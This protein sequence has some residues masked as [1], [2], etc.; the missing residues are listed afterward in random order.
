MDKKLVLISA[1]GTGGHMF[2]ARAL[3]EELLKRGHD[4]A[5]ATD[6]RGYKFFDGMDQV[7]RIV[8]SSAAYK[9]GIMGKASAVLSLLKG[10]FQS[11]TLLSRLKPSVVVGFG[12]YPSAPPVFAAQ[13][14]G[15]PTVLHEQNAILGLANQMLAPKAHKIA[16]STENTEGI[17]KNRQH[18]CIVTG[19]PVREEV[20]ALADKPY[21]DF[22]SGKIHLMLVGGSLGAKIFGDAIPHA[23][24]A[25]PE[26][27]R[28][29]LFVYHQARAENLEDVRKIYEGSGVET[30]IRPFFADM[31]ACLEKTHLLVARSGASTVAELTVAGRPAIYI[32][33]PWHKDQQQLYNA[34]QVEAAGGGIVMEEKNLTA[35]LLCAQVEDLLINPTK[36]AKMA[37]NAKKIGIRDA[38]HHLADAVLAEI[39]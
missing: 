2:P 39:H 30:D 31:P 20:A 15:I 23:I 29:N 12:G 37:E 24:V 18:Q 32:P 5:L 14:R 16:L 7:E 10:Y 21:P 34:K 36:L 9:S 33:F 13:H 25:L 4:V 28:K 3:A 35:N 27:L 8:I 38:A 6:T 19:N 22:N 1:G 17:D 11:H 26:E